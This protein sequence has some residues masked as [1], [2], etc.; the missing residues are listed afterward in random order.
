MALDKA[1][2]NITASLLPDEIKTTVGGVI[3]YELNDQG[4]NNKWIY[5]LTIIGNSN[6]DLVVSSVPFL[7][8]GT[9][10]EGATP[11]V[12][13]S[14]DVVF[15]FMKHTGTTDGTTAT[16]QEL[17]FCLGGDTPDGNTAK[18]MILKPDEVFCARIAHAKINQINAITQ[19]G[20]IQ[21]MVFAVID[22]G[23]V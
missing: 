11:T 12:N 3:N 22:D 1:S 18:E 9:S 19:S 2:V 14:D 13:S 16:T 7:G 21:V 4:D 20:N 10:E 5:S 6:E 8:Q 15:L 17:Y 23:G